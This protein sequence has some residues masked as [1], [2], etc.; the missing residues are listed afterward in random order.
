M[1]NLQYKTLFRAVINAELES[2]EL[3]SASGSIPDSVANNLKSNIDIEI[4]EILK[5]K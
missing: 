1:H 4:N 3:L 2:I 5:C